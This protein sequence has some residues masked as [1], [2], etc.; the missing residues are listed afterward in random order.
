MKVL[1]LTTWENPKCDESLK[2]YYDN[3]E[4]HREYRTERIKKF[5]VKQSGWSDGSGVMYHLRE[6]ESYEDYA[7]YMDDEEF[8]R[9]F[10]HFCRLVNNVKMK[11]LREAISAP[12]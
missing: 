8:Q 3:I 7:K 1:L 10:V 9:N 5:N 2:K 6:F 11:V 12:P 4:K